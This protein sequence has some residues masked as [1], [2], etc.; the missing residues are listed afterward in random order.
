VLERGHIS[1]RLVERQTDHCC[2]MQ[3][4]INPDDEAKFNLLSSCSDLADI[5]VCLHPAQCHGECDDCGWHPQ[6]LLAFTDLAGIRRCSWHSQSLLAFTDPHGIHRSSWQSQILPAIT[7]PPGS[8]R[9][10]GHSEILL[11][12]TNPAGIHRSSLRPQILQSSTDAS[13]I[14]RP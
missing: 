1:K 9:S 2:T 12:F 8:R 3:V 6:I 5:E 7:D 13:T 10:C 11:A 4:I 14:H